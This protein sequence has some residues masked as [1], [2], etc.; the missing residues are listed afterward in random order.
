MKAPS[1]GILLHWIFSSVLIIAPHTSDASP[2]VTTLET[3][4]QMLIKLFIG[5]GLVYLVHSTRSDWKSE[6]TSLYAWPPATI[7]WVFSLLF[8]LCA[9]FIKNKTLTPTISWFVA[10]TVGL[11]VLGFGTLYWFVWSKVSPALLGYRIEPVKQVLVDG[12][13]LIKYVVS[14]VFHNQ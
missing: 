14:H 3:Y 12:S 6:R 7:F 10:P 1:G 13:E 11:S 2:F 8:V 5:I 9:P 4:T